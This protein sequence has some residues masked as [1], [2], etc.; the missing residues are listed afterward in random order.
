MYPDKV[1]NHISLEIYCCNEISE[2]A[3]NSFDLNV[4]DDDPE[5]D[6]S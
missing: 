4:I 1:I 6:S 2:C 3:I 5:I